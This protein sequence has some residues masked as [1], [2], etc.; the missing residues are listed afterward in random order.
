MYLDTRARQELPVWTHRVLP[1]RTDVTNNLAFIGERL[2]IKEVLGMNKE[3]STSCAD[4]L[5][6]KAD[7]D[8]GSLSS[9]R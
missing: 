1:D 3:I 9:Q 5:V 2:G 8:V 4:V 7:V 6:L